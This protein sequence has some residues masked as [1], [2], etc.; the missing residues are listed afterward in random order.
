MVV[1]CDT[2]ILRDHRKIWILVRAVKVV[3]LETSIESI[4]GPS[5]TTAA[6]SLQDDGA[7][8]WVEFNVGF[9]GRQTEPA[10]G[11]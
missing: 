4:L 7:L 11:Y 9:S 2:V 10:L 1:V 8:C 5:A 3:G 6:L